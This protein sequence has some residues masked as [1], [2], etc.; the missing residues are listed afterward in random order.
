[1]EVKSPELLDALDRVDDLDNRLMRSEAT[2]DWSRETLEKLH[3][4]IDQAG[5][6]S[7]R[8]TVHSVIRALDPATNP[9]LAGGR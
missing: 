9:R 2:I 7:I 6:L 3:S 1:M 5:R 4:R 8:S